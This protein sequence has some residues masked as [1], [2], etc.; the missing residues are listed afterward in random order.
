MTL[1]LEIAEQPQRAEKTKL[2]VIDTDIH[3]F[4]VYEDP[5]FNEVITNYLAQEWQEYHKMIGMRGHYGGG[6]P[7][8]QPNAARTDAWPPSGRPPG[9]DLEFMREQLLDAWDMDYGILNPLAGAGGQVNREYGAQLA[10]AINDYQIAEWLE[11]E[12]RLRA[13]IVV[14][15][16]DADLAAQEIHRLGDHEGFVQIIIVARTQEPLGRRKYWKMYEAALEYD[17]PIGIHFGGLGGHPLTAGGWPSYYIEDHCGMAQ[18]FQAQVASLVCEGVFEHFPE[19][20]IV[21]IEG[22]FAWMPSLAWRL[23]QSWK[24]LSAETPYLKKAPS[25]YIQEHFWLST[26]PMEEPRQQAHFE[27]LLEQMD[28][29]RRLMFATDYPHW[30]FDSP[31]RAVPTTLPLETRRNIMAENA[32]QFY[33]LA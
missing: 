12:P 29:G 31:D 26:Q 11:L 28:G 13:S 1:E 2:A 25:E 15:Y 21:I 16:E 33:K 4:D 14:N 19:L 32:R 23:D 8:A 27:Q 17:L 24:K 30:D 6:Y 9:T 5:V 18:A 20:R 10:R 7:R 3:N 22:G